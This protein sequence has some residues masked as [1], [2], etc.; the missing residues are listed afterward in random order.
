VSRSHLFHTTNSP[1]E[2][3]AFIASRSHSAT[4]PADSSEKHV[5]SSTCPPPHTQQQASQ[6]RRACLLHSDAQV[7]NRYVRDFG[8]GIAHAA[9]SRRPP[10]SL[11]TIVARTH[12]YA[13]GAK[14]WN[15]SSFK[16][17]LS[18]RCQ[19]LTIRNFCIRYVTVRRRGDASMRHYASCTIMQH[20]CVRR[21]EGGARAR[22]STTASTSLGSVAASVPRP[23][24][25]TPGPLSTRLTTSRTCASSKVSRGGGARCLRIEMADDA[26]PWNMLLRLS[27]KGRG[28]AS[29]VAWVSVSRSGF[30]M[31]EHPQGVP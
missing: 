15:L 10:I 6:I 12:M 14:V 11:D 4:V 25:A 29:I 1:V 3:T 30:R 19:T 31:Q 16:G 26:S 13:H 22:T 28:T 27:L 2:P 20:A 5:A 24:G 17:F 21:R 8:W 23:Y 9:V 18:P 7:A